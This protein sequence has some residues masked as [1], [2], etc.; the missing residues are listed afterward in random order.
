MHLVLYAKVSGSAS[1]HKPRN[2]LTNAD[3]EIVPDSVTFPARLVNQADIQAHGVLHGL[4][5][6]A[7]AH[8]LDPN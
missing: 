3:F 1:R 7:R 8:R 5:L 2:Q 4:Q 6:K